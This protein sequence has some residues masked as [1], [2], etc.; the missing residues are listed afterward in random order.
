MAVTVAGIEMLLRLQQKNAVGPM[1]VT[2]S[3][4]LMLLMFPTLLGGANVVLEM[5][6]T[7]K[8]LIVLGMLTGPDGPVYPVMVMVPLFMVNVNCACVTAGSNMSSNAASSLREGFIILGSFRFSSEFCFFT[9]LLLRHLA[10]S[11]GHC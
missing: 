4:M 11:A 8:P 7:C 9:S 5:A 2:V 6:V 1:L 10:P 3:G